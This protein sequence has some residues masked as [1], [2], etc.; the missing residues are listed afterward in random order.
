[1]PGSTSTSRH[2]TSPRGI[3]A[4]LSAT[5]LLVAAACSSVTPADNGAAPSAGAGGASGSSSASPSADTFGSP[6]PAGSI[7][8]GGTLTIGLS[9]D[10]DLLDPT[11]SRSLYSRYIF[12][13]M[14][15]KLYDLD[16]TTKIVPQ[17]ASALPTISDGGKTV[18]IK[19]R[20]GVSFADG[21]PM[22]SAAV[23]TSL[24]RDLTLPTSARRTEIGPI[25]SIDTPDKST[26]VVHFDKPFAPFTAAL[27]DRAGMVMSPT[28]LAKLGKDFA[29]NPVCV[30]PFKFASRVP[31]TSI[32]VVRDPKYYAADKVHLDEIDYRIITDASIRDRNLQ[33]GD[34]SIA[35][36]V[37]SQD[38]PTLRAADNIAILSSDS[39]GW[40]AL[41]INVGNTKGVGKPPGTVDTP[42]GSKPE[43]RRALE[44]SIDRAGLVKTVFNGQA[45]ISCS[46]ISSISQ[47]SPP[48]T[49]SC[50]TFQPDKAKKMLADAGVTTP[51]KFSLSVTNSP[52][53][54]RFAQALQAMVGQGGFQMS[55]NPVEFTTILDQEDSGKFDALA[56]GWS[57]RVDPDANITS[58]FITGGAQNTTG[59]SDTQLDSLLGQA[60]T[61]T[62]MAQRRQLY[63]K[64]VTRL[65]EL[66]SA[67]FLYRQRNTTGIRTDRVVGVQ[68]Y[69]DGVIRTAYAALV[70]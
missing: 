34:V 66:D 56:L 32:K 16:Q 25:S 6:A 24:N 4:V 10:P 29:T 27:A 11:Q 20:S 50:T 42:L 68:V 60:R 19:L 28:A 36:S 5:T 45:T 54:L 1:M 23:K 46:P 18:T 8:E 55:I 67:I 59:T 13:N 69:P 70:K 44:L 2:P 39:L 31:S 47:F 65:Q 33:S 48:D 15:E 38:L 9:A 30:G 52:D 62:D 17:L 14:C 43:V 12:T 26:V 3:A 58:F 37:S 64:V 49:P 61:T 51:V 22:D 57:G 53:N 40:Q 35:D 7:R 41:Q 21:T 63:G